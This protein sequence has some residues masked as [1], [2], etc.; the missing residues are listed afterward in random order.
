MFTRAFY[1]TGDMLEQHYLLNE[2]ADMVDA[3][4]IRT[5]LS[6]RLELITAVNLRQAHQKVERGS[7]MGKIALEHFPG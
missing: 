4:K 1:Q 3:G 7:M 6:E 2:L 5:T